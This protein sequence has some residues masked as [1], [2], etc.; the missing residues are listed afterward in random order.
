MPDIDLRPGDGNSTTM[1]T[2]GGE[3][4]FWVRIQGTGENATAYVSSLR[5]R[6]VDV[7]SLGSAMKVTGRIPVQGEPIKM[8]MNKAQTRLYVAEDLSDTVDVIDISSTSAK[9]GTAPILETI[10]VAATPALTASTRWCRTIPVRTP[11]A[12]PS[13]RMSRSSTSPMAI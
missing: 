5:D 8:T 12:S 3:Y 7:V 10:K 6:E 2:P 1:G 13:R 4:P 9:N 11:T